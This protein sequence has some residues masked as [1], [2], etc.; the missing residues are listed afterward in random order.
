MKRII[1][2]LFI[3]TLYLI[4]YVVSAELDTTT[5]FTLFL[6]S[7]SPVPV[8][9]MVYKVLRDGQPS[10]YTFSERFYE[11]YAYAGNPVVEESA[12]EN[13]S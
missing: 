9:W 1:A 8:I 5:R 2:P 12:E 4:I 3:T 6:F 7:L 13:Q 10:P 11:D